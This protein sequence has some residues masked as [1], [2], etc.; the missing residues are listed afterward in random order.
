MIE[1]S[2]VFI[3][4]CNQFNERFKDVVL[5]CRD[6]FGKE[7]E[8]PSSN[9]RM[10]VKKFF[11]EHEKVFSEHKMKFFEPE[12]FEHLKEMIREDQGIN[13]S[14]IINSEFFK[15]EIN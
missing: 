10:T 1:K 4:M 12:Y 7:K 3:R 11:E 15:L 9:L 2:E 13:V 6:D 5:N 14:N 8:N